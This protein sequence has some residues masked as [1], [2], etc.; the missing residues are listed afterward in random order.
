MP[1]SWLKPTGN[2]LVLFEE[3][4]GDPTGI[5]L[6]KRSMTSVCADIFEYHPTTKDRHT[7]SNG[8]TQAIHRPKI[9]LQCSPGLLISS[10]KF[11][12]FGTPLGTCGT[13]Q[14]GTCHSPA[15]Y[16]VVSKVILYMFFSVFTVCIQM[17]SWSRDW[18]NLCSTEVHR[19]REMCSY[20]I[21]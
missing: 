8:K 4:G 11:A 10:I 5:S 18:W 16:D 9:H 3:L 6:V 21:K 13:F 1:R 17:Y 14:K 2:Q 12:S 20:G 19:K 15:S 7:E